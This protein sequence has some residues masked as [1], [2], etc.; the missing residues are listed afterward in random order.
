MVKVSKLLVSL[1]ILAGAVTSV[2]AQDFN[3]SYFCDDPR[4]PTVVTISNNYREYSERYIA[5]RNTYTAQLIQ[6]VGNRYLYRSSGGA[7][8]YVVTFFTNGSMKVQ[9]KNDLEPIVYTHIC[10]Q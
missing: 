5:G 8:E 2:Q 1:A 9:S 4:E 6:V 10:S 3:R 7:I